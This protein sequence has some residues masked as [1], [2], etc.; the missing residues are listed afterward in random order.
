MYVVC[1]ARADGS[2]WMEI[3]V[4]SNLALSI[5]CCFCGVRECLSCVLVVSIKIS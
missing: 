1:D 4:V 5:F 3:V 2:I